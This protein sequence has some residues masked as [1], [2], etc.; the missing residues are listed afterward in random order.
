MGKQAT[1][2]IIRALIDKPAL[3]RSVCDEATRQ[4]SKEPLLAIRQHQS[5][6]HV[7]GYFECNCRFQEE[8]RSVRRHAVK[9][10]CYPVQP[11]KIW[12]FVKH[13]S[14]LKHQR[15]CISL[16]KKQGRGFTFFFYGPFL[17]GAIRL[18]SWSKTGAGGWSI[19]PEISYTPV[20]SSSSPAFSFLNVKSIY[21]AGLSA[22][23]RE[24]VLA[25]VLSNLR[26]LFREGLA[27][28][29]R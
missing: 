14:T 4:Q 27:Q 10:S 17:A 9:G 29:Y 18:M 2:Q 1:E 20:V 5:L 11:R 15:G 24:T 25:S 8:H 21:P 13:K 6:R 7:K 12:D 23:D 16:A 19:S 28:G 26:N 3:L 22:E